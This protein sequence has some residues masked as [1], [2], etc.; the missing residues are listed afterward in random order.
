M[1]EKYPRLSNRASVLAPVLVCCFILCALSVS[2]KPASKPAAGGKRPAASGTQTSFTLSGK[3]LGADGNGISGVKLDLEPAFTKT[4]SGAGG[5]YAFKDLSNGDY[6]LIPTKDRYEFIPQMRPVGVNFADLGGQDFSAVRSG[7]ASAVWPKHRGNSRNTAMS[8]CNGPQVKKI[9][10]ILHL[11]VPYTDLPEF[12]PRGY[13]YIIESSPIIGPGGLLYMGASDKRIYQVDT[14]TKD[15]K[16]SFK[17]TAS[18]SS[19]PAIASDGT[20]YVA[21]DDNNVCAVGAD[22]WSKWT[23]DVGQKVFSSPAIGPD[24]TVYVATYA[25]SDKCW[26]YALSPSNGNPKW[27]RPLKLGVT[28]SPAIGPDGTIYVSCADGNL[29]ALNRTNGAIKWAYQTT[30]QIVSSPC[31][32]GDGTVYIGSTD[33]NV[34]AITPKGALKWQAATGNWITSAFAI[35][36]DETIYVGSN[37]KKLYALDPKNGS[38]KWATI[39]K[40]QVRSPSV[41]ADGMIYVGCADGSINAVEPTRGR[42][43]WSQRT[44]GDVFY[45]TLGPN[46]MLYAVSRDGNTYAIGG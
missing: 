43:K 5:A 28:G 23:Y 14:A 2:C 12:R 6:Q 7:L 36:P 11:Y 45:V 38:V 26:V 3:I 33:Y 17:L 34:Y 27:S 19:T 37:D 29:Y 1:N 24:G 8:T 4:E 10:W 35:G 44:A 32:A 15:I 30:N 21:C 16:N 18:P 42:I 22:G 25:A 13:T 41:A 39:F 31:V 9:K 46:N 40:N 20:I